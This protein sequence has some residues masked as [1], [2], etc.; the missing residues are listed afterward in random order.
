M[1]AITRTAPRKMAMLT[2][3]REAMNLRNR[4]KYLQLHGEWIL[5]A[6]SRVCYPKRP[7]VKFLSI[8]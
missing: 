8:T 2:E 5:Q 1:P 4:Y 6:N 3:S 7:R